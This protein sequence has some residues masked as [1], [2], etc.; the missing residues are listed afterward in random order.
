VEFGGV[1]VGGN[2]DI[3]NML[4][5]QPFTNVLLY[6]YHLVG[7]NFGLAIILFTI[8]IR[9]ITHPLMAAQIKGSSGMQKLQTDPRYLEMQ[10]K[11]K[12]DREKLAQEQMKLYKDLGI[13]PVATCLPTLIQFPLIIGL[14]QSLYKV[15]ANTPLDMLTLSRYLYPFLDITKIIPINNQFLWMD[16]SQPEKVM[17][18]ALGFGIPIMAVL[19]MATTFLQSRLMTP[20]S[21]NPKDQSAMMANMMN[22]YMPFLMGYM[23]LTLASGLSLYFLVSN[24]VSVVQYAALGKVNWSNILPKFNRAE[25]VTSIQ[26]NRSGKSGKA[27]AKK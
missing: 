15:M 19:V 21:Q 26:T 3:W 20:P 13:N 14:Y 23:A 6:I 25:E 24:V 5:I 2:M 22:I 12:N 7:L 11:Y 1:E 9:L 18:P 10:E 16:L 8:L 27:K 17:I 4:I